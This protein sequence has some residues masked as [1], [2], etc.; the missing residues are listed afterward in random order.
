VAA[1]IVQWTGMPASSSS[2]LLITHWDFLFEALMRPRQ[3]SIPAAKC[4]P[5]HFSF[6]TTASSP[7]S[8]MLPKTFQN[9]PLS[10]ELCVQCFLLQLGAGRTGSQAD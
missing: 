10:P 1:M 5:P 9:H 6:C 2:L 8:T 3:C 7:Y 4:S